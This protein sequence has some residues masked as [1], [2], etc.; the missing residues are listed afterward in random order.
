MIGG[1]VLS[2][3]YMSKHSRNLILDN[4]GVAETMVIRGAVKIARLFVISLKC[5][6]LSLKFDRIKGMEIRI[7]FDGLIFWSN[8]IRIK[9]KFDS[10]RFVRSST[11]GVRA[12]SGVAC[13]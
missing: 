6:R 12:S 11:C 13:E 10:I 4:S 3:V 8:R 9:V 7:R 1:A 5:A 2:L